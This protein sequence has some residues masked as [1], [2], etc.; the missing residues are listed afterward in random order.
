MINELLQKAK[1]LNN[2]DIRPY[3]FVREEN[4]IAQPGSFHKLDWFKQNPIFK[5]PLD[6]TEIAFAD[7]IYSI[8][9]RAFGPS[10]MAMPRWVFYDCAVMPGFVAGFAARPKV[11]SKLV[12]EVLDPKKYP[13][14]LSPIKTSKVLK[15]IESLDEMDWVPLSLF[16]II[17][18]MHKGEW[19]AHN[20]CSV[21]S[22]LPKEEQFY[23][24]GF[25]SKAFG[26]WYANVEQCSGMTQWGSPALKL[27][28][29]YGHL[30]VIGAYA[31]VHSHAKTITYRV[32]VN[33]H[34]WEKFF[35]KEDDLA[36]LEHYGPTGTFIDPKNEDSMLDFQQRIERAEGPFFLS[37]GEIAQKKLED[38]LMI[39]Q[40]K[41]QY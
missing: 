33:T 39:Y 12:R 5:N 18:T 23:G 31:P 40:L 17:P 15:E 8:E 22:L 10:N 26:L 37:A 34:C 9:E 21:N 11:L 7:R 28:S 20:L 41:Q 36:F 35:N 27:H 13:A 1:W 6:I 14:S 29:H 19:V 4:E 30:E 32:Q 25:L 38:K 2:E 3:V 24:L 16:I